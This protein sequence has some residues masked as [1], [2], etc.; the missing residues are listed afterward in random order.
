MNNVF[1]KGDKKQNLK[2]MI[3]IMSL[4]NSQKKLIKLMLL[5]DIIG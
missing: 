1:N 4:V 3:L 5:L 2:Y